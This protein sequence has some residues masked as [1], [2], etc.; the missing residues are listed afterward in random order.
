VS[1]IVPVK[2]GRAYLESLVAALAAQTLPPAFFELVV[3][4][5]GSTDGSLEWL[6]S[7]DREFVRVTVGPPRNSYAARNRAA[8]LARAPVLAFCDVDCVPEPEWLE[9][10]LAALE[11]ADVIAGRIRFA[12]PQ[13]RT[14]WTLL[15]MDTSKDHERQ[16][17][18][19]TAETAN[20]FLRRELYERLGGFEE[21]IPEF[22]D[23]DFV[24]RAVALGASL[25]FDP[26]VVAW[27]PTRDRARPFLRAQWIYCHGYGARESRAG[28]F[29]R[30]LRLRSLVPIVPQVRSRRWWGRS[31]GPDRRWLGENGVVPTRT[32]TLKAL[33]LMYLVVPYLRIAAQ[34]LG[35]LDGRELRSTH[36]TE[37]SG[38]TRSTG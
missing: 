29:P 33:P 16:V 3:A 21:V 27:H 17:R 23:F 30:D 13:R 25:A 37:A 9:R 12:V 1:V 15:D 28:R 10:G 38:I 14:V 26:E 22:G 5:D 18:N 34:F 19:G 20:L 11:R 4:D 24:Q 35:W 36:D 31:L 7:L 2:N 32:E 6:E 8:R